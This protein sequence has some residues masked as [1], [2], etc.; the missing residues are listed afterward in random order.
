MKPAPIKPRALARRRDGTWITTDGRYHLTPYR[1]HTEVTRGHGP[2]R[3]EVSDPLGGELPRT[4]YTLT[5]FR[6]EFCAPGGTVPWL[7]CCMDDGVMRV[8][9]TMKA[10]VAWAR[11][12]ADAPVRCRKHF[13][14]SSS[15]D[16]V[17]GYPGEDSNTC[18]TILRADAAHRHGWDPLQQ[19]LYPY[20]SSPYENLERD[21]DSS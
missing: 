10:A 15:Y 3:W 2:R 13:T 12:L 4:G 5:R 21:E 6:E 11:G 16:Y 8:E 18:L 7:V 14:N 9:P 1:D 20:T 17:F 19:P